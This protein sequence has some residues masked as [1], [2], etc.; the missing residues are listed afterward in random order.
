MRVTEAVVS[1]GLVIC[2]AFAYFAE[3]MGVAAIIGAYMAGL[4]ASFTDYREEVFEKVETIAYSL[5]VPVF[6]PPSGLR[7]TFPASSSIGR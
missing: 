1:A 6:L 3:A 5:F 4:G 2:F 7:P